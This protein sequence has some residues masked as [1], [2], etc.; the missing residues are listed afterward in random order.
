MTLR[1]TPSLVPSRLLLTFLA[2]LCLSPVSS[3]LY[4]RFTAR[5]LDVVDGD[6][7]ILA[8]GRGQVTVRIYGIDA[9]EGGQAFGDRA[10]AQLASRVLGKL[11]DVLL[12]DVDVYGRLVA[13]LQL[14]GGDIGEELVQ[15]GA[16][17]HY[18]QYSFR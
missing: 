6:T 14:E 10:K 1:V 16:A 17:W 7:L 9:P 18:R 11:V 3:A 12:R 5:V 13:E 15:S 4:Q 2:V 8:R